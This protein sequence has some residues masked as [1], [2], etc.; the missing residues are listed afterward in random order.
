MTHCWILPRLQEAFSY[1]RWLQ[2][3][4]T[5]LTWH[6]CEIDFLPLKYW[7]HAGPRTL[8]SWLR[9]EMVMM[10][11][12]EIVVVVIIIGIKYEATVRSKGRQEN[13]QK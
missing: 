11:M 4:N 9:R 3:V 6:V 7:F 12:M 13:H 5:L 10:M 1:N 2:L 8:Q